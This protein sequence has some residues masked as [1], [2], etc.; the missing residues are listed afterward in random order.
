M[1]FYI[2]PPAVVAT[3]KNLEDSV[4]ERL[5][6]YA[7]MHCENIKEVI[8]GLHC[9]A[10]DSTMDRIGNFLFRMVSLNNSRFRDVYLK[11]E[12]K[13]L[14]IR[15]SCYEQSQ[16][17]FAV[18]K[19]RRH[20]NEVLRTYRLEDEVKQFILFLEQTCTKLLKEEWFLHAFIQHEEPCK[21]CN[22][23]CFKGK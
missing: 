21:Q 12:V 11:N 22:E 8:Q 4:E 17:K 3:V 1:T 5:T 16:V 2:K 23:F 6:C 13:I 10:D 14:E 18:T 15:L 19:I 7:N 9:L 20:A